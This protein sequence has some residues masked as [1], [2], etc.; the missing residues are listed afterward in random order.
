LVVDA[1]AYLKQIEEVYV[2]DAY[3]WLSI[4]DYRVSLESIERVRQG[5]LNLDLL[6][7]DKQHWDALAARGDWQA[8]QAVQQ[9]IEEPIFYL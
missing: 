1:K 5:S 2:T 3:H 9:S 4:E 8:F 6:D 7:T